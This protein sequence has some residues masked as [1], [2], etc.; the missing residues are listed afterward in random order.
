MKV[1]G[2]TICQ[3]ARDIA[4]YKIYLIQ[5]LVIL[6]WITHP[7]VRYPKEKDINLP[8]THCNTTS[9]IIIWCVVLYIYIWGT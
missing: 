8:S 5:N 3:L 7:W 4:R 2:I 6:F 1:N 9:I